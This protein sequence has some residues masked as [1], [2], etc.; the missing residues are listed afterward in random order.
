LISPAVS[1]HLAAFLFGMTGILG[2]LIEAS[3]ATITFGRAMFA[4]LALALVMRLG[5]ESR[6]STGPLFAKSRETVNRDW[7]RFVFSGLL[8]AVHW[9][10]FFVSVKAAGVAIATLGFSSF[11][12]FITL[13]EWRLAPQTVT[14]NDWIRLSFVCAGLA[15]I[16]PALDLQNTDTYGFLMGLL[17]GLSFAGMAVYNSRRLTHVSPILVARNQNLVVAVI[18]VAWAAPEMSALSVASWVWLALLGVFCTGLSH[19]LFVFSLS[20]M[21]VNMAGLVIALEPVYAI[22]VAWLLFA[23]VPALR[24]L[25]GGALIVSAILGIRYVNSRQTHLSKPLE[26]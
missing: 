19:A 26:P 11:A 9:I 15:L 14:R 2:S 17:S 4:V 22:A 20:H 23:Q 12:A 7:L 18:L 24:T 21:R 6:G 25:V 13:F 5:R 10:S 3:P 16:T 1:I 8:L